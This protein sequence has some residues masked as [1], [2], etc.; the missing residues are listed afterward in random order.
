MAD[1]APSSEASL[2]LSGLSFCK[3]FMIESFERS[4][5]ALRRPGWVL[6]PGLGRRFSELRLGHIASFLGG[7]SP[8]PVFLGLFDAVVVL[9]FAF[10]SIL[11]VDSCGAALAVW[12]APSPF[13]LSGLRIMI[14]GELKL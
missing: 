4:G 7:A 3:V 6:L 13:H 11:P 5:S 1:S 9:T 8:Q 12:Y 2:C 10:L 14:S